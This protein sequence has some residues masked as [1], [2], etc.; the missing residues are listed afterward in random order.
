MEIETTVLVGRSPL[1]DAMIACWP[2][3]SRTLDTLLLGPSEAGAPESFLQ[4][5]RH[6][7]AAE[8][9][10]V[11]IS[12]DLTTTQRAALAWQRLISEACQWLGGQGV[13]R[14]NVA[15]D[16]DDQ[17]GLQLFRQLGFTAYTSD[18][19]FRRPAERPRPPAP[20]IRTLPCTPIHVPDVESLICRGLPD[21]V[22]LAREPGA[23]DWRTYPLGGRMPPADLGQVW[24]DGV[25]R[26]LGAWQ[27]FRGPGGAW[28][29][30]VAEA[31][32]DATP[33]VQH[34]LSAQGPGGRAALP[35]YAAARGYEPSLNLAF[36]AQ[37][38]VPLVRRFRLV[39][40]MTAQVRE[41]AWRDGR[42]I[43]RG[44]QPIPSRSVEPAAATVQANGRRL[45]ETEASPPVHP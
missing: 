35:T 20:A 36:R 21:A 7:T 19:V 43:E 41:P 44:A 25:G 34:A 3:G 2:M 4:A 31:E 28:L 9:D 23:S 14:V 15:V 22:R 37:G 12:P 42:V 30:V 6:R 13:Q 17:L 18:V 33:L 1:R 39:K 45:P 16:E 10:L 26:V 29:R 27:C 11:F 32:V 5:R 8:A 24:V 40:A 38:F